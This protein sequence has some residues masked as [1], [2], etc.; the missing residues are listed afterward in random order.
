MTSLLKNC[1]VCTTLLTGSVLCL[2]AAPEGQEV[3]TDFENIPDDSNMFFTVGTPPFT[4]LFEYGV[5]GD[6]LLA[7][8]LAHTP[9]HVWSIL[10]GVTGSITFET[11]AH[12]VE[13]YAANLIGGDGTIEVYDTH[14]QLLISVSNLPQRI[15]PEDNPQFITFNALSLGAPNGISKILLIDDPIVSFGITQSLTAIDD[16][17]FTPLRGE[18]AEGVVLDGS[19]DTVGSDIQHPNGNIFDQVLLT[20][21][22]VSVRAGMNKITR[23]SFIDEND[24]I[25]QAEF[26]G[27]GSLTIN[28]DASTFSGQALPLKYNQNVKYVKGRA[29]FVIEN[30]DI[31]TFFSFFSVGTINAV[32]QALFPAGEEY[33]AQANAALLEI[34]NSTA[35]GAINCANTIFTGSSGKIGIDARGVPV[36]IR[37]TLGDIEATDSANPTLIVGE[38]SFTVA[39]N[40]QGMRITGG[41]LYQS[42]GGDVV[43]SPSGSTV[44]GFST[45]ISQNNFKSDGTALPTQSIDSKFVN[46]DGVEI[47]IIVVETTVN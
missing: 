5:A 47:F 37:A 2:I 16:F 39:G 44:G 36:G 11:P 46:E 13:F 45:L 20:G 9:T 18:G 40:N 29:S 21:E 41:D 4:A 15:L 26:S 25:V 27:S 7:T 31:D 24:D 43:V 10:N 17:G 33:N 42:N 34:I 23:V 3:F 12:T 22:S 30:A 35:M 32:N 1:L 28:L 14:N 8:Q 19:G 6:G 38:S